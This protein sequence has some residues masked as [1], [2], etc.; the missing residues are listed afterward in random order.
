MPRCRELD[1]GWGYMV[2]G[3]ATR[4][5]G[6]GPVSRPTARRSASDLGVC[7]S[8]NLFDAS[9]HRSLTSP[10]LASPPLSF[11]A[12]SSDPDP[13]DCGRQG[14]SALSL[15]VR[16]LSVRASSAQ[17]LQ[18]LRRHERLCSYLFAS[19]CSQIGR[20]GTPFFGPLTSKDA[21]SR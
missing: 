15:R 21:R 1:H 8:K 20:R 5:E 10:S 11:I 13:T 18:P 6:Q 17:L 19:S 3:P 4:G 12:Q 16:L 14:E 2:Q 9:R 7:P